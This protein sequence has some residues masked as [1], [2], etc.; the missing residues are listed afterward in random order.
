MTDTTDGRDAP[1][2]FL[3]EGASCRFGSAAKSALGEIVGSMTGAVVFA[4]TSGVVA[5][6]GETAYYLHRLSEGVC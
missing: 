3:P 4:P 2:G 5:G 6:R 1:A